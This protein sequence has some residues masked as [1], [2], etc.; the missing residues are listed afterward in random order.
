MQ[1]LLHWNFTMSTTNTPGMLPHWHFYWDNTAQTLLC[2]PKRSWDVKQWMWKTHWL[3][4]PSRLWNGALLGTQENKARSIFPWAWL[5]LPRRTHRQ[6]CWAGLL[7]LSRAL[8]LLNA[9]S[10]S[11]GSELRLDK[12]NKNV[13]N[14][15]F[16]MTT[17]AN[18]GTSAKRAGPIPVYKKYTSTPMP[19]TGLMCSNATFPWSTEQLFPS[20][21][22]N[23]LIFS[24]LDEKTFTLTS[25]GWQGVWS[26]IQRSLQ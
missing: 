12:F 24:S 4:V 1:V 15:R 25:K 8:C 26:V 10:V 6:L 13:G 3:A 16:K 11:E 21:I 20:F 9:Q 19:Q 5:F 14:I 23:N 18:S 17:F 22:L 7:V 2:S